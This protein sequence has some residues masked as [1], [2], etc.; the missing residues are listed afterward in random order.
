VLLVDDAHGRVAV[1]G[2]VDDLQVL[3]LA[4]E[5]QRLAER[6]A[7]STMRMVI[8]R[9]FWLPMVVVGPAIVGRMGP[10]FTQARQF[11]VV[12]SGYYGAS[13]TGSWE[14]AQRETAAGGTRV[15]DVR[16]GVPACR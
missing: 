14:S 6:S 13:V 12:H 7:A 10:D 5:L 3:L 9:G 11:V 8:G 4:G 15:S 1:D 16:P 2:D